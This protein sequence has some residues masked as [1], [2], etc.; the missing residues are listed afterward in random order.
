MYKNWLLMINTKSM[1]RYWV[2][3][4]E[5]YKLHIYSTTSE[6]LSIYAFGTIYVVTSPTRLKCAKNCAAE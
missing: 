5:S 4:K 6:L 3:A 2:T 1:R